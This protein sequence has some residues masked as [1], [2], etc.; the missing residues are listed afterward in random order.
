MTQV[1]LDADSLQGCMTRFA[2]GDDMAL[3]ELLKRTSAR[4]EQLTR[5]M[6]QDFARVHR[7]EE[8]ADVLQNASLRLY[9]ALQKTQPTDVRGFYALAA[10]QI[11]R[12]LTDL[13]RRYFGPEGLGA[14][15]ETRELW[16]AETSAS[17]AFDVP[18]S[19][20]SFDPQRL[21]SWTDFHN[22]AE[23]LE[24]DDRE[25]FDLIYYQGLSQGE[26]AAVL[27]VSERTIQRRWQCARLALHDALD[28]RLP[29]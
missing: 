7:W 14:N 22:Q 12:E 15:Y 5:S 2:A 10:L 28:G 17:N 27:G 21:A 9:R 25:V 24:P 18:A 13:A 4:M 1:A 6:F 29:G 19:S 16:P 23:R 8:T 26:A 3:N 11:R 20:G